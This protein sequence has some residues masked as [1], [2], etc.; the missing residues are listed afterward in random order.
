MPPAMLTIESTD[1]NVF[2]FK[3]V[4]VSFKRPIGA[5]NNSN[6][7]VTRA[8]VSYAFSPLLCIGVKISV[9]PL[10]DLTASLPNSLIKFWII[11]FVS[12]AVLPI[13]SAS[14][15]MLNASLNA[16]P[17]LSALSRIDSIMLDKTMSVDVLASPAKS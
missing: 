11:A 7:L 8:N 10:I 4:S 12:S 16:N 14:K 3:V 9:N 6:W 5:L 1:I 15:W 17:N 13:T 2:W